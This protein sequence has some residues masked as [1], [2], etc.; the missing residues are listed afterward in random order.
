MDTIIDISDFNMEG[1]NE[2]NT[3]VAPEQWTI[4][5]ALDYVLEQAGVQNCLT[6]FCK[7]ATALLSSYA[8]H[9]A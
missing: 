7:R 2:K 5:T 9:W 8:Q 6:S 4:I 3:I 1:N